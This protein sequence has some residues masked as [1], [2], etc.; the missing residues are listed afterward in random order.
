MVIE[1]DLQGRHQVAVIL[2]RLAHA[3][4][5]HI[6]DHAVVLSAGGFLLSEPVLCKP[7]LGDDLSGR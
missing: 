7:Q 1:H 2:Q 6:G 3:H 4:H 5:H